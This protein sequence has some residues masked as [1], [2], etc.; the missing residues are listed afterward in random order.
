MKLSN[1]PEAVIDWSRVPAA[2]APG[3]TGAATSRI[4]EAGDVRLRLVDYGAGYLADHWCSKGH[5]IHVIDGAL[6]IEHEDGSPAC[7]LGAGMS[8]RASDGAPHRVRSPSGAR[9]FIVD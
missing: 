5:V 2:S 4:I 8:W 9:V 6:T 7:A 3:A 1:L